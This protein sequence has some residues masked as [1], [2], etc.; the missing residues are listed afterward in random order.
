VAVAGRRLL[1]LAIP[2]ARGTLTP[3][4]AGTAIAAGCQELGATYVKLGQLLAS[5]PGVVGDDFSA[6]FRG[7]LDDG[8]PVPFDQVR[9]TIESELGAPLDTLFESLD[10]APLAAASMA[11]VHRGR[12]HDGRRVAVKVL[13]PGI[14]DVLAADLRLLRPILAE[15]AAVAQTPESRVAVELVDGLREQLHEELDL[16]RELLAM[17]EFRAVLEALGQGDLVVPAPHPD[18]SSRRVLTM[19]LLDGVA[20]DDLA[21]AEAR[22]IDPAPLVAALVRTWFLSAIRHGAFHGDVHAGNL[23]LLDDGRIALL[24]WGIVGRLDDVTQRLFRSVVAGVLGDEEAWSVAAEIMIG[25][26]FT[27]E[28]LR[29]NPVT[30][31]QT[32]PLVRARTSAMLTR[33]LGDVNLA[34]LL[35]GPP[36]P[37]PEIPW[38][39][40]HVALGRFLARRLRIPVTD[41]T[42]DLPTFD[43]SMFLLV[44]QL[45]YFNRYG[46]QHLADQPLLHEDD[47]DAYRRAL[48][49]S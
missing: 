15:V 35:D 9:A 1:P 6:T 2:A 46:K 10:P 22:G 5:A 37:V 3:T 41:H 17:V 11:V 33:P 12:L 30:V 19:Q 34:E 25:R 18:F 14:D 7:L 32:V 45:V 44:K 48:D 21:A 43:R 26:L 28:Q 20:I 40:P 36:V 29:A 23:L 39:A 27:A 8:P 31:D 13:R 47:K 38:P 42:A 49:L 4:V 16:R 24:D